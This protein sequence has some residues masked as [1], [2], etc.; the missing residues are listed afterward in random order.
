MVACKLG[1]VRSDLQKNSDDSFARLTLQ[2]QNSFAR[3]S[4]QSENGFA[5]ELA[6]TAEGSKQTV[7]SEMGVTRNLHGAFV[8]SAASTDRAAKYQSA[9]IVDSFAR[10]S[11]QS[12]NNAARGLESIANYGN[13]TSDQTASV[14]A[15]LSAQHNAIAR[16][17]LITARELSTQ[18]ANNASAIALESSRQAAAI[19]IQTAVTAKDV[20]LT[21]ALNAKDLAIQ[22]AMNAKDIS[23]QVAVNSKEALV[24]A[25]T[26]ASA[27]LLE[28]SKWFALAEKT[29]MVN[30]L[31][32]DA[33][34]AACCCEIKETVVVSANATQGLIQATEAARVRDALVAVATENSILRLRREDRREEHRPYPVPYPYPYRSDS[35]RRRSDSPP[36]R[37]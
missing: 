33:K 8:D 3:L 18:A 27:N 6:A 17:V 16:D 29:A 10:L 2:D 5:S 35:P 15:T 31:D 20:A 11:A 19:Q 14:L 7:Q 13:R 25:A 22:S 9:S 37:Q 30:K 21:A 26:I 28:N 1:D 24:Q 36:R 34:L 32:T 12:E 4:A 23:L